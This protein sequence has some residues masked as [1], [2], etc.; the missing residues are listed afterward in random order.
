MSEMKNWDVFIS[1]ASEDKE[2]VALPLAEILRRAGLKVWLDRQEIQLGDSLREKID[3]GLA[4]SRFGVVVLSKAFLGKGWPKREL[5]GLMALEDGGQKVILPVWHEINKEELTCYSPI[6]AD[7]VAAN[8]DRGIVAV[9]E[10]IDRV[11]SLAVDTPSWIAPT[12]LRRLK[13]LIDQAVPPDRIAG[14][15]QH[16]PTLLFGGGRVGSEVLRD[17][18]VAKGIV[19]IAVAQFQPTSGSYDILLFGFAN[20]QGRLL[21][22]DGRFEADVELQRTLLK[23]A[24][25]STAVKQACLSLLTNPSQLYSQLYS[26]FQPGHLE[27]VKGRVYARRRDSLTA[28]EKEEYKLSKWVAL[29]TY[30]SLLDDAAS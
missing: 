26:Y 30:D 25:L 22:S 17:L 29:A 24:C 19:R 16:Y 14:F 5:N 2:S 6:L 12:P 8:T 9:A 23:Q 20:I 28:I 27:T 15:L 13:M 21:R 18:P 1:H 11:V 3:D 7:R 10:A 4:Q